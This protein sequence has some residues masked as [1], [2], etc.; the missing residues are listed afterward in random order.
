MSTILERIKAYKLEEIAA[1]KAALPLA[2]LEAQ[3]KAAL[4][5]PQGGKKQPPKQEA[6]SGASPLVENEGSRPRKK[7]FKERRE[8]TE[9]EQCIAALEAEKAAIEEALCTG[10]L[11]SDELTEKSIRLSALNEELDEKTM[12]WLELSEIPD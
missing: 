4:L 9:V 7:T 10:M 3:A 6:Q 8:F 2:D 1:A 5:S 11:A 12:R